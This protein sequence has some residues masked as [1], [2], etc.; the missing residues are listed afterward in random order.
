MRAM[1]H[2]KVA[3]EVVVQS[4]CQ[5]F[6][7][8]ADVKPVF[9]LVE[10]LKVKGLEQSRREQRTA[11]RAVLLVIDN[12]FPVL[13]IE[14]GIVYRALFVDS[15]RS[16]NA[17]VRA[18]QSDIGQLLQGVRP[19]GNIALHDE[20]PSIGFEGLLAATAQHEQVVGR[21]LCGEGGQIDHL[22]TEEGG[23]AVQA[24]GVFGGGEIVVDGVAVGHRERAVHDGTHRFDG[25]V[26]A[27]LDG[28]DDV[29]GLHE[30]GAYFNPFF[31]L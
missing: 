6:V 29:E 30:K 2:G 25:A 11:K 17:A 12:V 31:R 20:Q 1:H 9:T 5:A 8:D 26:Y 15:Y 16:Y 27:V 28:S 22:D 3:A 10:Q 14:V 19:Y 13:G 4:C 7:R 24:L 21:G 18:L 23:L